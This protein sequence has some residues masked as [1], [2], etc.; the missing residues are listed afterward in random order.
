MREVETITIGDRSFEVRQMGAIQGITILNELLRI[1]ATP[2]AHLLA[3]LGPGLASAAVQGTSDPRKV[4][5]AFLGGKVDATSIGAATTALFAQL[6]PERQE[7]VLLAL[8]R[9][10]RALGKGQPEELTREVVDTLF[11]GRL[12]E[13]MRLVHASIRVNY[14]SFSRALSGSGLLRRLATTPPS[15]TSATSAGQRNG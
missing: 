3:G 5:S 10:C 6:T 14:G 1:C 12:D 9:P 4:L 7:Q 13:L 15:G 11:A 2:L 8:L